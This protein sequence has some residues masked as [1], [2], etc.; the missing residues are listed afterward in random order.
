MK[1]EELK[2]CKVLSFL[3]HSRPY[4]ANHF[5]F[6]N[7]VLFQMSP[8]T[9]AENQFLAIQLKHSAFENLKKN[10]PNGKHLSFES[11]LVECLKSRESGGFSAKVSTEAERCWLR[12]RYF[13][14]GYCQLVGFGS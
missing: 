10:Q 3:L 8:K 11:V 9:K 12:S 14:K 4:I 2:I 13:I 5:C 6:S 1:L 7:H